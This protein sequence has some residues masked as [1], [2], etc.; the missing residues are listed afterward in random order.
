M[1]LLLAI[2]AFILT[3]CGSSN[4]VSRTELEEIQEK[5]TA[6]SALAGNLDAVVGSDFATCPASG[7]TADPLIR[8]ICEVAHAATIELQIQ[9]QA[10]MGTFV[11]SL[12][13]QIDAANNDLASHQ[14]SLAVINA[15]LTNLQDDI[16]DLDTRLTSAE[17]AIIALQNLTSSITGTLNGVMI[18]LSIGE[19][20]L[21]AGPVYE[22][23]LR[24]VDKKRFNGY[25]ESYGS[26]LSLPNDPITAVNGSSTVTV[27]M[28]AHGL[29][30]GNVVKITDLTEG[31]GFT[32]GD[33]LGEFEVL[34]VPTANS[35]TV[36]LRRNATSNGSLGGNV[37]VAQKLNARGMATLWKSG[38]MSD[39]VV[40]QTTAGSKRYNFIIRRL[41]S[42]L[43]NQTAEL[44][45]DSTN[46]AASFAT[47]NAASEGGSGNIVCK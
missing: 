37:G 21:G 26:A 6:L 1:R 29:T 22:S 32:S 17:A 20:N 12:Q 11:T 15:S 4:S 27:S 19:E 9:L 3:A 14:T 5:I 7:D 13:D 38:D 43:T 34:S 39:V 28:T 41:V 2:I 35:F 46:R 45:Y 16:D 24:R 44:C 8:K 33:L 23:V 40:R 10:E 18:S 31:R 36:Q 30:V 25:V 42:D 47:I